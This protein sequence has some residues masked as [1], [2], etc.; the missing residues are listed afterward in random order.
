VARSLAERAAAKGLEVQTWDWLNDFYWKAVALYD[1]QFGVLRLI[2][3]LMCLLAVVGAI[4]R[5]RAGA[6]GRA[7]GNARRGARRAPRNRRR[8]RHLRYRHPDAAAAEF[9]PGVSAR[10]S[11]VHRWWL[12]QR[13]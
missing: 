5:R 13:P 9:E 6:R 1:R 8:A 11:V 12:L 3:L 10:I 4:K 7:H 2:V